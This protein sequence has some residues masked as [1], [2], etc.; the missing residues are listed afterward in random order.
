V[1][2]EA[3]TANPVDLLGSAT[4]PTYEAALPPVLADP[5]VDSLIALFVPPVVASAEDVAATIVRAGGAAPAEKPVLAVVLSAEGTPEVLRS[6]RRVTAF[7]YPESAA[8]A[9][10]FAADRADWLRRPVGTVPRLDGIDRGAA[11]EAVYGVEGWLDAERARAVLSAYGIPLVPERVAGT[12]DEAVEAAREL[13]FPAVVKTARAGAH[14]TESGGVAIGL[15]DEGA[16]RAAAERIGPPVLVQPMASGVELLA[17]VVQDPVFG[18]LVAFGPG[19][20]MAELIGGAAFRVAPL[21][22]VDASELV[23][24]GKAGELVRGF[25]GRPGADAAALEE[26]LHRLARLA[27]DLPE[28]AELDLNPIIA[29]PERCV[30]VDARIR[31]EPPHPTERAKTW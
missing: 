6:A 4:A 15:E 14:K 23:L 11:R 18:P 28:I 1:P 2:A 21:T 24:G 20:V 5:N 25:R 26:L 10:A 8:R 27:E 17:G 19:G 7:P 12:V 16:V 13:G 22:D 29:T 3:S 30:A 9:L 31:V